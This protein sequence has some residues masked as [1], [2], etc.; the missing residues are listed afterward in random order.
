LSDGT[1]KQIF[2]DGRVR[3]YGFEW[4]ADGSGFYAIAPYS[5]DPKFLTATI[6]KDYFYDMASGKS[7]EISS[8]LGKR[9]RV[10]D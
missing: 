6:L 2:T 4:A 1:E 10:W 9:L 7:A 8:V 3:P 5:T